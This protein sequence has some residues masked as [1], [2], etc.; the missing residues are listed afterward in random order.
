MAKL[1]AKQK[2]ALAKGQSLM[3]RAQVIQR[4]AGTVTV[5]SRKKFKMNMN[6]ALK[7][8]A[9]ETSF[10]KNFSGRKKK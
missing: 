6:K 1:S 8:A 10:V 5:P 3:K 9:E 2:K 7:E 4:N